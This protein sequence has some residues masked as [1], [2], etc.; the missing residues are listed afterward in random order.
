MHGND[1]ACRRA[2]DM[3]TLAVKPI[4]EFDEIARK[5]LI[6]ERLIQTGLRFTMAAN[7]G[8]HDAIVPRKMRHPGVQPQR[9]AHA[10]VQ[11]HN[12]FGLLP[13][14]CEIIN[15][16]MQIGAVARLPME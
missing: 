10:G 13:R 11:H 4:D 3:H 14:I 9:A 1:A 5:P 6:R 16:I 8:T 15:A 12:A 2:D 7:V